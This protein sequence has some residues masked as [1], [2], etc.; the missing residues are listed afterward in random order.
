[1]SNEKTAKAGKIK[2]FTCSE[3]LHFKGIPLAGHDKV[4]SSEGVR[5]SRP[6]PSCFTPNVTQLTQSSDQF[7]QIVG[8]TQG[9]T[10]TQKRVLFGLLNT[11]MRKIE[12]GV[13]VYFRAIGKDYLSNYLSGFVV[14]NTSRGGIVV[15]GDPD[16]KKRGRPY[17]AIFKST[18]DLLTESEFKAKKKKLVA[19]GRLND[20]QK[21][22]LKSSINVD[23]EPPTIDSTFEKTAKKRYATDVD[24]IITRSGKIESF[25]VTSKKDR[26]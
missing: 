16:N 18:E 9:L 21:V 7:A 4:C 24:K 14:T 17:L 8:I 25:V 1:M 13:K 12:F 23:Y 20:P 11:K 15:M 19:A 22:L 10:R 6:A 2:P 26:K 5:A 3:C